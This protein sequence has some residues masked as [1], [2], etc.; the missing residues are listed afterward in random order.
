MSKITISVNIE[1][2]SDNVH[3]NYFPD[4][5]SFIQQEVKNTFNEVEH[6]MAIPKR[7]R[8]DQNYLSDNT[9]HDSHF[10]CNI[11]L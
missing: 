9:I 1:I 6:W 8:I 11:I 3:T 2:D 5:E 4:L 10:T 7:H